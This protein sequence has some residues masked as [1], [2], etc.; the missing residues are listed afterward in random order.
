MSEI[1]RINKTL[2]SYGLNPQGQA[3]FRVVWSD[4]QFE[5]RRGMFE[6]F[7][8][9][10]YLKTVVSTERKKK[11]SYIKSRWIF[12]KW[13]PPERIYTSELPD[14]VNG[15]YECI[16]VFQDKEG[17]PLP[18][19]L[20]ICQFIAYTLSK[21]RDTFKEK[22]LIEEEL[23]RKEQKLDQKDEDILEDAS[24]LMAT[25]LHTGEAISMKRGQYE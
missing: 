17:N 5:N 8:K 21:N 24:P 13:I 14:T 7:Y 25:Q 15:S 6:E 20:E 10:I 2:K 3:I 11:Y 18:L 9:G 22:N 12:E 1:N 19:D 4:E 23:Q 16:Y